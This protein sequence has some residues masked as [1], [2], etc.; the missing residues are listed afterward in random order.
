MGKIC[1]A[2]VDVPRR[3][4]LDVLVGIDE[5]TAGNI[6]VA[7]TITDLISGNFS[8]RT[9]TKPVTAN[10]G[11]VMA[12]VLSGG[13]FETLEDGRRPDGN[14]DYGTYSYKT[15]EVATVM[16]MTLG[17]KVWISMEATSGAITKNAI[18]EPVNNSYVP[19]VVGS[20]TAGTASAL[21][22]MA[23]KAQPFGGLFGG[24]FEAGFFA[25]VTQ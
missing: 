3:D 21:K 23:L 13:D 24:E 18:L 20:R 22:V 2:T 5:L 15:G 12:I 17:N 19:T 6:V 7:D 8:V 9:A 25:E 1:Y 11:K 16:V 10:L 14:P 4:I